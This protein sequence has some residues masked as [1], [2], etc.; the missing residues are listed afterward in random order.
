MSGGA[1]TSGAG[2]GSADLPEDLDRLLLREL[3]GRH[4]TPLYVTSAAVIRRRCR[5]TRRAFPDARI[6]YAAK[7]NANPHVL[8]VLRRAGAH[9]DAVS[10]GEVLAAERAGFG[11]AEI[12][13]T[14]AFP[15]E[16][17]LRAVVE[18]GLR[19]NVNSGADLERFAAM[20]RD[21][22]SASRRVGVR[23]D[24]QVG[25][26]H[27]D[28]VVTAGGGTK[29]GVPAAR[30]PDVFDR[31]RELGLEPAGLHMHIGSGYLDPDPLLRAVGRLGALANDLEAA[32]HALG[33]ID[34]GG[35]WGVPYRPGQSPLDLASLAEGVRSRLDVDARLVVEPGRWLVAE[36]TV[37]LARTTA[38]KGGYVGVDAGLHTLL[39]PALYGAYHHVTNLDRDTPAEGEPV[40]A[41]EARHGTD[42]RGVARPDRGGRPGEDESDP[43]VD[44]NRVTV[45]GPICETGDVLAR[46]RDLG[47]TRRGD[48]LAVHDVG[49][50]GFVMAS[51]YN[52][53]PLPAEVL[54][55]GGEARLVRR[56][57][58]W[59]DLFSTVAGEVSG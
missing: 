48:L 54:V 28:H 24:P 46:D 52:A 26:G 23:V 33:W 22:P 20:A 14:G 50:Y 6:C 59:R 18:R 35:G 25:A 10:L 42:A 15:P 3:A 1:R 9:V 56:R 57:E 21:R 31:A 39:R 58:G 30:A 11:P 19:V 38:V 53:R 41:P 17:E 2:G 12:T 16:D 55:D 34:V 37:L 45:V 5:E 4:G 29:F 27:H 7:A 8:A 51:R 49:A 13:Y 32:G 40:S 36:S 44:G 47:T 43:D